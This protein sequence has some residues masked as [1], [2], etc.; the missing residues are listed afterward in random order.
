MTTTG[1]A[2]R[3]PSGR[4]GDAVIIRDETLADM[5]AIFE[6]TRAA[7][8]VHPYSSHTEQFIV[9]ALRAA[10]ALTLSL[11]AQTDGKVAGHIAFSPVAISDGSTDWYG[12]GPVSVVPRLQG[13]GI[14]MALVN[15]GLLR[16]K[17]LGARGC[18]L[19]GDPAYYRRFGFRNPSCL[20]H[21][22]APPENLLVLTFGKD[23]PRGTVVFHEGFRAKG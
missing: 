9:N 14:G 11:V 4:K 2:P 17:T 1:R 12:V 18:V 16:L 7:F 10:G 15:Q 22:G 19:V 6:V 20:V 21:E 5:A 23:E 3:D 13:R 8:E